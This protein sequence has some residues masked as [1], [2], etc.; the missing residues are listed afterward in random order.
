MDV[1]EQVFTETNPD[2]VMDRVNRHLSR[3]VPAPMEPMM[4][5]IPREELISKPG[6]VQ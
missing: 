4:S 6:G 3:T 1:S 5:L 2:A